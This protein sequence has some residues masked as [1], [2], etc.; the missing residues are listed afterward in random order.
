MNTSHA[1]DTMGRFT[2]IYHVNDSAGHIAKR[3]EAIA[4]EQSVE[5]PVAAI[6]DRAILDNIV[7]HVEAIT[8][9]NEGLFEVRIGLSVAS[10]GMEA[11]QLFNMLFGNTSLHPDVISRSQTG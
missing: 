3:A 6:S 10:T 5:M 7:G 11:G 8:A 4:V 1:T 2:A 9:V